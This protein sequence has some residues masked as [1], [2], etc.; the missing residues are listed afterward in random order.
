MSWF[1]EEAINLCCMLE[2]VAPKYG[3]HVA[4]TGGLLYKEGQR[5]DADVVIYRHR[6]C[7]KI[8]F[9][10]LFANWESMGVRRT[11]DEPAGSFVI[12]AQ[13]EGKSIDFLIPEA[14]GFYGDD[15]LELVSSEFQE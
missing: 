1:Q 15:G 13:W 2:A 3:C 7:P 8:D 11:K 12:K 5:K 9:D 10:G 14:E 4:L 6:Q